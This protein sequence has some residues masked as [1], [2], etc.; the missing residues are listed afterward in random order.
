MRNKRGKERRSEGEKV[1][2]YEELKQQLNF[3]AKGFLKKSWEGMLTNN[4]GLTLIDR[5]SR[6]VKKKIKKELQSYLN[7]NGWKLFKNL[8][9][10]IIFE[11][12]RLN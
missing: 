4:Q 7:F 12:Q 11:F 3:K 5:G 6:W 1:E 2:K 10:K 8:S 9:L